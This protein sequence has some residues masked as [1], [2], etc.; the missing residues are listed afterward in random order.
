MLFSTS[1]ICGCK[2]WVQEG[3]CQESG[4][5]CP[6]TER[7]WQHTDASAVRRALT[8]VEDVRDSLC[9]DLDECLASFARVHLIDWGTF[10]A[11]SCIMYCWTLHAE[12]FCRAE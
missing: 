10:K 4:K 9:I 6:H 1:A 5:T 11:A 3:S 7:A 12:C 8:A 2:G